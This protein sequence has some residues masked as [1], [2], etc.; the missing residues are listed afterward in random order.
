MLFVHLWAT[1]YKF[2][3]ARLPCFAANYLGREDENYNPQT[4]HTK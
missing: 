4:S 2:P 1:L 3:K